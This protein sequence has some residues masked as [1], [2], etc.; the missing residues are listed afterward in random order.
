MDPGLLVI[1][2]VAFDPQVY[3]RSVT[4]GGSDYKPAGVLTGGNEI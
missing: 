1:F 2:Q 4:E 3:A